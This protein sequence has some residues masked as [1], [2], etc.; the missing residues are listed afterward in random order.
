LR[1]SPVAVATKQLAGPLA[2]DV[3]VSVILFQPQYL[4]LFYDDLARSNSV[5]TNGQTVAVFSLPLVVLNQDGTERPVMLGRVKL[6]VAVGL[7]KVGTPTLS[8]PLPQLPIGR[9]GNHHAA[10]GNCAA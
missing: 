8:R 6:N 1:K 4:N 3:I 10:Q 7:V 5:F 9:S 2:Q